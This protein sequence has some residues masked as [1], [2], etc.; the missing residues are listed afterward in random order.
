MTNVVHCTPKQLVGF[1]KQTV[2]T[3][4]ESGRQCAVHGARRRRR[5]SSQRL[6]NNGQNQLAKAVVQGEPEKQSV[7]LVRETLSNYCR[8]HIA[9]W[10]GEKNFGELIRQR[11]RNQSAGGLQMSNLVQV[12]VVTAATLTN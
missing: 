12:P 11:V 7:V 5:E 1:M 4:I 3:R 9:R 6:V 2:R 8:L 10:S